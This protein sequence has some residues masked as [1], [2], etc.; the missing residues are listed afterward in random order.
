MRTTKTEALIR[1]K[2]DRVTAIVVPVD[3]PKDEAVRLANILELCTD[4]YV[5]GLAHPF[6][7]DPKWTKP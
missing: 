7:L 5:E 1:T 2:D 4:I 6:G 3:L